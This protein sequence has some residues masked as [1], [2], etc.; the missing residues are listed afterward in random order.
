MPETAAAITAASATIGPIIPPSLP[1]VIYGVSADVSIGEL[2]LAGVIPGL[3]MA[4]ALMAH[5]DVDRAPARNMPRQPV[6]R[7]SRPLDAPTSARIGR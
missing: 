6:S 2:F 4:G 5:G 7:P 3:L 1:M